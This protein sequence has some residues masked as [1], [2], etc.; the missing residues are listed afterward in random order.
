MKDATA[1]AIAIAHGETS[2]SAV[3]DATLSA[4]HAQADLGAVVYLDTEMARAGA[5]PRILCPRISAAR[6]MACPFL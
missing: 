2:A 1:L 3:M 4:C 6:F 5:G